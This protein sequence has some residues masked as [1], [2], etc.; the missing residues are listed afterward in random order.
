MA[1]WEEMKR[2]AIISLLCSICLVSSLGVASADPV[3][4]NTTTPAIGNYTAP[5]ATPEWFANFIDNI[6]TTAGE[7]AARF[8]SLAA[9]TAL[10]IISAIYGPLVLIGV[11]LWA[12]RINR[13]LGK[14]LIFGSVILLIVAECAPLL[15][16]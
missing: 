2:S 10:R 1:Q 4:N 9:K 14:N 3:G 13:Q 12:T 15:G 5:P 16:I 11:I 6:L 7:G 8:A